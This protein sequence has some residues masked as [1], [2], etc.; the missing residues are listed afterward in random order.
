MLQEEIT[1]GFVS[2]IKFVF[3]ALVWQFVLFN[4]GRFALLLL[5]VGRYPRGRIVQLHE[6]RISLVG[7][8][9]L[10]FAW[11]AI[12]IHNNLYPW[13]SYP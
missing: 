4:V 8:A 5:T 6:N 10:L 2:F 1:N 9:A 13:H 11:S 3:Y 7:L 12:A